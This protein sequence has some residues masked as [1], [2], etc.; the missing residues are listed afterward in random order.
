M[1]SQENYSFDPDAEQQ[2]D[3]NAGQPE[4]FEYNENIDKGEDEGDIQID[5]GYIPYD[6]LPDE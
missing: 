5:D 2:E 6:E 4:N 3:V 1:E